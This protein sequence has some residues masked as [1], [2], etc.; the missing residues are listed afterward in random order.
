MAATSPTPAEQAAALQARLFEQR[1]REHR[2]LVRGL[3]SQRAGLCMADGWEMSRET[4][5]G[6]F[7]LDDSVLGRLMQV[8]VGP[9]GAARGGPA[10]RAAPPSAPTRAA[11]AG[12]GALERYLFPANPAAPSGSA[13]RFAQEVPGAVY[14]PGNVLANSSAALAGSLQFLGERT[15][16]QAMAEGLQAIMERRAAQVRLA[17]GVDLYNAAGPRQQPRVRLRVRGLPI[18]QLQ[19]MVPGAGGPAGQWRLGG[20]GATASLRARGMSAE[21][22]RQTQAMVGQQRLP[23]ALQWTQGRVGGGVLAFA[24]SLVLDAYSSIETDLHT[25]Q[26][27]FNG[28]AFLV[29]SA[30]SQS[31]NA[32]GFGVGMAAVAVAAVFVAGWP[33][34]LVGLGAGVLAQVAW[35]SFGGSDA[36]ERAAREALAR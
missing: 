9:E 1:L 5:D 35:S 31:G 30:R 26:R 29:A 7:D 8:Q 12:P 21:Q 25:G 19:A 27:R 18:T 4:I 32:L 2:L 20:S 15:G 33:L 6:D 17:P 10:V 3:T 16:R 11:P 28:D 22:L 34:I 13:Q 24:P 14:G 23:S 36:A